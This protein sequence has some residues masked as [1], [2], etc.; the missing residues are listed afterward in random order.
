MD[1][2]LNK[3]E[4]INYQFSLIK[5]DIK[6]YD[7]CCFK[8]KYINVKRIILCSTMIILIYFIIILSIPVF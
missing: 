8:K 3:F 6:Y 2:I 5:Y 1:K 4:E 7:K